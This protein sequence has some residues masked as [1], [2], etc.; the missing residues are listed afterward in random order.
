MNR[1]IEGPFFISKKLIE[2]INGKEYCKAPADGVRICFG[3]RLTLGPNGRDISSI[4]WMDEVGKCLKRNHR[5]YSS[6]I[7]GKLSSTEFLKPHWM[8]R[9]RRKTR[10]GPE[11]IRSSTH[12]PRRW[13]ELVN[14][15]KPQPFVSIAR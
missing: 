5:V 9:S 2:T 11:E 1:Q 6:W 13:L 10:S 14:R 7:L 8:L 12:G 15:H 4:G 3:V